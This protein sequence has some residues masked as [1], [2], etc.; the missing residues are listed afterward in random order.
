MAEQ[1]SLDESTIRSAAAAVLAG[2]P[3]GAKRDPDKVSEAAWME[4]R[5]RTRPAVNGLAQLIEPVQ[6]CPDLVLP[7]EVDR[8]LDQLVAQVEGRWRV[9]EEWKLRERFNRGLGVAALFAGES[10][11]GKTTAAEQIA[12]RVK[13]DLY[14]IDLSAVVNKYIGETEKNLKRVFDA[15]EDGGAVLFFD[16]EGKLSGVREGLIRDLREQA[17]VRPEDTEAEG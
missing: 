7:D 4:C 14:R 1:F 16:A 9:Y 10:G 13:L 8:Q 3:A 17:R 2:I 6:D 12:K 15:F 11:T 5:N